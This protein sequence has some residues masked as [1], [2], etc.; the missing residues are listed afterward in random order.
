MDSDD[1]MTTKTSSKLS[2]S[3]RE[4]DRGPKRA[5]RQLERARKDKLAR[6]ETWVPPDILRRQAAEAATGLHG[7]VAEEVQAEKMHE[8]KAEPLPDQEQKQ[9]LIED[10]L[11]DEI[12]VDMQRWVKEKDGQPY[13]FICKKRATATHITSGE[14]LKRVEEDALGTLLFGSAFSTR[15]FHGDM[16]KGIPTKKKR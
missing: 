13:C 16:C 4:S 3:R 15:R 12:V 1:S 2:R 10:A 9:K 11:M 14:H 8:K 7:S 6:G 5:Q